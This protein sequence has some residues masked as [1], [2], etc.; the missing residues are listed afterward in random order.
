MCTSCGRQHDQSTSFPQGL[1]LFLSRPS[2]ASSGFLWVP[3]K[4]CTAY[5]SLSVSTWRKRAWP[6]ILLS[7]TMGHLLLPS[8]KTASSKVLIAYSF[9]IVQSIGRS[10]TS[11]LPWRTFNTIQW[12]IDSRKVHTLPRQTMNVTR[13][14]QLRCDLHGQADANSRR[15]SCHQDHQGNWKE[16][17]SRSKGL[18]QCGRSLCLRQWTG[19]YKWLISQASG[20]EWKQW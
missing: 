15:A 20:D 6:S 8:V 7:W 11:P 13:P 4:S 14:S 19:L 5:R 9:V 3:Y 12:L 10:Q 18:L 1:L 16:I 17:S 2:W